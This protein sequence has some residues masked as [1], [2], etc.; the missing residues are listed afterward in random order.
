MEAYIDI[1]RHFKDPKYPNPL[2]RKETIEFSK[3]IRVVGGGGSLAQWV[4][5]LL[6]YPTATGSIPSFPKK[7]Q[8][9]GIDHASVAA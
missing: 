1:N 3:L 2:I 9:K 4:A 8:R 5:K 7:F 6:L